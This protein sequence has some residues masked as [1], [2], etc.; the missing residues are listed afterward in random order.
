MPKPAIPSAT[1][2]ERDLALPLDVATWHQIA[3]ALALSPQQARIVELILQNKQDK[4]IAAELELSVATI[5]TYL[6]RIFDRVKVKDRLSLILR[7][8]ALAQDVAFSSAR[9]H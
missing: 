9:H 5:R 4:E 7:I 2:S 1:P 3:K 6:R 8:F